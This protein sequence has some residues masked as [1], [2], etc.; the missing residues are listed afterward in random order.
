MADS[1]VASAATA[2]EPMRSKRG[3]PK[4]STAIMAN[5]FYRAAELA[6]ADIARQPPK[7]DLGAGME[8]PT[9]CKTIRCPQH[10]NLK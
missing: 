1:K 9:R 3:R 5:S 2:L 10:G 4:G 6:L 8:V 7:D